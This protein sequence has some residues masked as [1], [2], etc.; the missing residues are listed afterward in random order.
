MKTFGIYFLITVFFLTACSKEKE[1]RATYEVTF[2]GNWLDATHGG[3]LPSNAHFSKAVGLTHKTGISIFNSDEIASNGIEEMAETGKTS[4]LKTEIGNIVNSNNSFGFI[5]GESLATS[6][7]I[8]KFKF[9]MHRDYPLVTLVS[10][11]APS[12]DWFI[13]VKD[14]ELHNGKEFI[15]NTVVEANAYDS[16]TDNGSDY[17]SANEDT[18]PKDVIHKIDS[19]PSGDKLLAPYALFRF[20]KV[21]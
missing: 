8:K 2:I 19:L 14:I 5:E 16:G 17:T 12:P 4:I 15:R 13:A 6:V 20:K 3:S 9:K 10:M 18:N 11:I 21:D 7:G 1:K